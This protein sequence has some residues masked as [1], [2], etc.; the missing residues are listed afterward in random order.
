MKKTLAMLLCLVMLLS[1]MGSTAFAEGGYTPGTYTGEAE[2][3]G[4][5]TVSVTV[6][7]NGITAVELDTSGE[8][9]T[10][11]GAHDEEF[12][13]QVLEKGADIDG[14]SGASI[15]SRA[16]RLAVEQALAQAG[17]AQ[18]GEKAPV[19]D[20]TYTAKAPSYGVMKEME[21]AVTF[22]NNAI[23]K[24]ETLCAGSATQADEDEY[25]PIYATVENFLFPRI[26]EAQSLGVDNITGATTSSNAAKTIIGKIIDENGGKS[27]EWYTPVE[28]STAVVELRDYDVIVVGLG[29][30]GMASYIS[31]AENGA[32]VF[33]M[34]AAA[35][36]GGNGTNTAGPLGVN[37]P[38]H[39]EANNGE[40]FVDPDELFDA[41]MEYTDG[42]AKEEIVKL[43]IE[44]SGK[45]FGWLEENWDFQFLDNMFAFYDVHGWPLWTMYNDKTMTSKDLAYANSMEMAKAM[46]EKNDYMTELTAT[47]LL[48]DDEGN[49]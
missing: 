24:I 7:E 39:V 44:E 27:D 14:I 35:K 16:I 4:H 22:E 11:G 9:A 43:F 30:S 46:N 15:T 49:A 19:A 28:K 18:A 48:K 40:P 33:G 3:M 12:I 5:V 8:T 17:G 13:A 23:T 45:T 32:T 21:L 1:L 20:G 6:D 37:P 38:H 10:I 41:W 29:A 26:I 31:A 42:D 36:V 47:K 34:E 25:S 2:G